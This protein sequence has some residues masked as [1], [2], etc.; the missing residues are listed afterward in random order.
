MRIGDCEIEDGQKR[1][2]KQARLAF[3]NFLTDMDV[4]ETWTIPS[5]EMSV[6]NVEK[7]MNSARYRHKDFGEFPWSF[8][9]L[10]DS[11]RIVRV[12]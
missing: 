7:C 1:I 8:R 10:G 3:Y 9:D 5:V 12:A 6:H 4:D 11:S 2:G